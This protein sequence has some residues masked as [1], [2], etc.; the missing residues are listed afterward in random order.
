[1][2]LREVLPGMKRAYGEEHPATRS[3]AH[4]LQWLEQQQPAAAPRKPVAR[5]KPRQPKA[6]E[7]VMSAAEREDAEARADAA[8]A[9]LLAMTELEKPTTAGKGKK[10]KGK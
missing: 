1:M 6:A 10:K 9:E 3:A 5:R 4:A 7:P 2:I 8:M